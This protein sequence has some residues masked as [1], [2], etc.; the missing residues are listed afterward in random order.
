MK[1]RSRP[2]GHSACSKSMS[3]TITSECSTLT[4]ITAAEKHTLILIVDRPTP[5]AR[6]VG[7]D[8]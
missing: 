3:R 1:S 7:Q 5:K 6:R 2:S 4:A 8:P